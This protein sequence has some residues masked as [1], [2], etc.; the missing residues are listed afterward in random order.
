[1][2]IPNIKDCVL[3]GK[4]VAFVRYQSNE[5]WYRCENG[6]E[7]PVPTNDTGDAAFLPEDKAS[8]FQRWINKHISFLSAAKVDA[9]EAHVIGV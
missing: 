5:L 4:K 8:Y 2:N 1:M 9:N 6:F 7:F 3:G